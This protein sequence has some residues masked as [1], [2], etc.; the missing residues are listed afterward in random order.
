M[1]FLALTWLAAATFA[2]ITAAGCAPLVRESPV[3]E[4]AREFRGVWV[5][6]VANIDWPSKPG[7]STADQKKELLALLDRA[8]QLKLN[9]VL[10]QVRPACDAFYNSKFEPW[11]E[12]LTGTMGRAPQPFYDPLAFAVEQAHARGLE[13]HAWFN[14]FRAH[15]FQTVSPIAASHISRTHPDLVRSYGKYLWLDPGEPAVRDYSLSVVLDVVKRY[16]VDG[17]HFDDYFY[18]YKE[19]GANGKDVDFP[20]EAS[21]RKFGVRG[22]LGR[23]D[24][25][26]QNVNEFVERVYKSIKTLKPWVKFGISPFGIWRPGNPP[27]IRGYDAY[28]KLYAD[29]RQWLVNGWVD[30]LAPQLYWTNDSKEQSFSALLDWWSHQNPKGREIFS[31]IAASN[32]GKWPP[33]E[34]PNQIRLTRKQ[35]GAGGYILYSLKSLQTNP[36]LEQSLEHDLN[37]QPALPPSA[38]R[39]S[40]SP[41]TP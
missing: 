35:P 13:L 31:G 37:V 36:A 18:P 10:F 34:I 7:L 2:G 26:R 14:P 3:R 9:A 8:V 40:K 17:I 11:S 24:W 38:R 30:Y 32:A 20:D 6:T 25:R 22:K 23:D 15:H 1:T 33:E 41:L 12:Y 16:D 19:K 4:P 5:A 21:W 27:Q 39:P 28:A 29:S